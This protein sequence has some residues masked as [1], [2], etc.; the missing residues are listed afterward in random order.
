M[1]GFMQSPRQ[2]HGAAPSPPNSGSKKNPRAYYPTGNKALGRINTFSSSCQD[3][4]NSLQKIGTSKSISFHTENETELPMVLLRN[5]NMLSKQHWLSSLFLALGL[6]MQLHLR[7]N[8]TRA[9]FLP[10]PLSSRLSSH[11]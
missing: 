11:L 10:R 5:K 6:W 7:Q 8:K 3:I 2:A 9:S 1:C 4:F